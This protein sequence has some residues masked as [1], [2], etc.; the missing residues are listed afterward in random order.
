[1]FDL[2]NIKLK[3]VRLLRRVGFRRDW[4]L[5][6]L[7][8]VIGSMAGVVALGF[9]WLV[10][11]FEAFFYENMAGPNVRG[12]RLWMLV[13]LPA[14]G[15]LAV[16]LLKKWLRLPMVSHGI[17]DVMESLARRHGQLK[18]RSGMSTAIN[19]ALTIGSG[20]SAGQ[21]G[22]IV[23][24]GSVLGSLMGQVLRVSHQHMSTL[25]GCGAAGA[26][27]AIFNAPIAGVLLVLEVMLRDFSLKTFMP[28]VVS[29][30]FAVAVFQAAAGNNEAL[31][32]LTHEMQNYTFQIGELV[33]YLVMG[34][35]IGIVG[36]SFTKLLFSMEGA[37]A[38]VKLPAWIKPAL[39]GLA[40]GLMGLGFVW[41]YP[42][43]VG[44]YNP[45]AFFANGY[46]VI[47]TLLDPAAYG[48]AGHVTLIFLLT[49]AAAKLLGTSLT[50][51]SGGAGGIFAPALFIGAA[52]G[53][54]FGVGLVATGIFPDASPATYALA[55]MAGMLAGSVHCP[56]TAFILVFEVTR[57]YK[58]ILPVML[59]SITATVVSQLLLR[60]SIYTL[61]L[62]EMGIKIGVLSEQA[63]LHKLTADQV[64][65]E[66]AVVVYPGDSVESLLK[67]AE[68]YGAN[69]FVVCDS[70]QHF[71]GMVT[72][73]DLRIALLQR[74][75]VPLL[76]VAEMMRS[77][78]PAVDPG[79]TLDLVLD[80]FADCDVHSLPVIDTDHDQQLMGLITRNRL[81]RYYHHA[82]SQ[83]A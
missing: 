59:V 10:E 45:P 65:L 66:K 20:G 31:F 16:G 28:V 43:A 2:P 58:V 21:E 7:S 61:A 8:A 54:A 72:N 67:L 40:L 52:I 78:M 30:V 13:A 3:A 32:N 51:G 38:R 56:L 23:Q 77:D 69:D 62:R 48:T 47:E 42:Y 44:D 81:M 33:P 14:A 9:G 1:M 17:P 12:E 68:Q 41:A 71:V 37:W 74:E 4:Y 18:F 63:V 36:W 55:G 50:L 80:K 15:G 53:G 49:A 19:S 27:A 46:P 82:L 73:D 75:A 64:P 35:M 25:V 39:G 60:D 24:I 29:T 6:P 34:I 11:F 76:I 5:I 22:P 26:L 79:E 70:E 57:D 83:P